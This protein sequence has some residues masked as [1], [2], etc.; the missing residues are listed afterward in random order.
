MEFIVTDRASIEHGILVRSAYVVISIC[1]PGEREA[2]VRKQSG[3][4]DVLCLAFHDA[5]P[6]ETLALPNN[7]VLMTEHQARQAWEFVRKWAEHVGS[8]VVH[9]EQGMSRSPAVAAAICRAF[10]GDHQCFFREYQPNRYV[11]RL[12]DESCDLAQRRRH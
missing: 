2:R 7:I 9:C 1:D 11:F 8:I 6:S 12:M 5:E 10:G 3:L 4:R